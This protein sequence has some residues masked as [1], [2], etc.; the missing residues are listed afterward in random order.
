MDF[1]KC[2]LSQLTQDLEV[3]DARAPDEAVLWA[4][5]L[6]SKVSRRAGRARADGRCAH[7]EVVLAHSIA[8]IC[9]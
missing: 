4:H 9:G 6:E 3:S 1:T 8:R 2:S 7:G 5:M